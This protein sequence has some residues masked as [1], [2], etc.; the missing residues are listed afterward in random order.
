MSTG[1]TPD[2][3]ISTM[4][5][6]IEIFDVTAVKYGLVRCKLIVDAYIACCGLLNNVEAEAAAKAVVGFAVEVQKALSDFN[7]EHNEDI[8]IRCGIHIGPLNSCI[9]GSEVLCYELY[10]GTVFHV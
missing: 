2:T 9:M 4:S 1:L 6:L 8:R 5:S 3:L 10:G 7:A